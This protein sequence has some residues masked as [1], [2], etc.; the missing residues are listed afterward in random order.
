MEV[1]KAIIDSPDIDY[2]WVFIIA[3]NKESANEIFKEY[4]KPFILSESKTDILKI[5]DYEDYVKKYCKVKKLPGITSGSK[6]EG[7]KVELEDRAF[8]WKKS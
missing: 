3:K 7:V 6:I 2:T 5:K 1:F 4:A 8:I